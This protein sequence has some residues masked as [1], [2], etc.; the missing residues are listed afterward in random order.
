MLIYLLFSVHPKLN[1]GVTNA[2]F[3]KQLQFAT[4]FKEG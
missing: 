2:M 3:I 4:K 1:E